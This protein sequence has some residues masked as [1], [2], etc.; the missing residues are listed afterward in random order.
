[1]CNLVFR[2]L[3]VVLHCRQIE[4]KERQAKLQE[5][6]EVK[7]LPELLLRLNDKSGLSTAS[8]LQN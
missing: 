6:A 7:F 2:H 1:M 3:S 5:R 4:Q 8:Q